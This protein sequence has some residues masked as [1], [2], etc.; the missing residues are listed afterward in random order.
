M[1]V[2]LEQIAYAKRDYRIADASDLGLKPGEW[3]EMLELSTGPE[4]HRAYQ[5][6]DELGSFAGWLYQSGELMLA[7][8]ND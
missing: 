8:F 5:L 7:V 2:N 3:P 4:L 1:K 6:V